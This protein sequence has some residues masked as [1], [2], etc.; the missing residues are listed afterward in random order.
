LC[1]QGVRTDM[2]MR[3]PENFLVEGSLSTEQVATP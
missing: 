2:L 1:P 3:D